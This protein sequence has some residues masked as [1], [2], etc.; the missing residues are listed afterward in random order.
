MLRCPKCK[1]GSISLWMGGKLGMIYFCK[2]CGYRGPIVVEEGPGRQDDNI[3][4]F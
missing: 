2:R 3:R 1:S 4:I